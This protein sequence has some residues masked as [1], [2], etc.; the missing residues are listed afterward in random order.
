MKKIY[1]LIAITLLLASCSGNKKHSLE[2]VLASNDL[3]K[4]R[5]KKTTLNSEIQKLSESI[6]ALDAKIAT[7]D[8]SKKVPLITVVSANKTVFNHYL[9]LQGDVK[10]KQNVL[11][12][13]EM[14]GQL[15]QIYVKEGQSVVKGQALAKIDDAGLSNKL[16]QIEIQ[17]ALAKTTYE[18][19][20][21]L[22]NQK[23][24]SEIQFLQA[25]TTFEAQKNAVTQLKK[26]LG[27]SIIKAPFS[28]IIDD[29]IKEQGVIVAPGAKSEIFRI[30]NLSKMYIETAVPESYISTIKK[31]KNVEIEFPV[32][33]EKMTSTVRQA[34]NFINPA[35]RTFNVEVAVDNKAKN[36][37][38]NLTAKLKINDYTNNE[39]LLIPQ[40][41]ISENAKGEQYLYVVTDLKE[42][43][44]QNS[45][46]LLGTAKQII[47][48]T[49]KTQG[50]V[51]EV[52]KG[53]KT[54]DK[55]IME[56]A[57]SVQNGQQVQI[58]N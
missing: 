31:G 11:I 18:R 37:K 24:G 5:A 58:L 21:R 22:W 12:Y 56:G 4:I 15:V 8:T 13:P 48:T 1:S 38:P 53:I 49:G 14:A 33:G 32:L 29:V 43:S 57:R 54:G 42:E 36:I 30:V 27:K 40:S 44:R 52:L 34:G 25:K 17:T 35:N 51:V 47:I 39:A 55:I 6:K 20:E 19:Q 3:T 10:T 16:A 9:E 28:G 46:E 26:Q 50:D 41:I 23:I 2:K 45:K 7:L